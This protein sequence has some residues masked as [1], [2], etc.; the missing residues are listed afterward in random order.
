LTGGG[1]E[2]ELTAMNNDG[3]LNF[4]RLDLNQSTTTL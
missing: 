2:K 3:L 1:A 4:I